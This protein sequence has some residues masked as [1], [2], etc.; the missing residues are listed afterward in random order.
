MILNYKYKL[1]VNKHTKELSQLV[2]TANCVRNHIVALYRRYYKLYGK[3]P[4]CNNM[5]KHIAKIAK[6]NPYWNLMGSQSL[7]DISQRIEIGYK[8]F[9]KKDAKRPP[10]FHKVNEHG[11]FIFKGKVGYALNGNMLIINKLKRTYKFKLTR[12]YDKVKNISISRDNLGQLWLI[13]TTEVTSHKTYER[14]D[15]GRIGMDFGLKTFITTSDNKSIDAPLPLKDNLNKLRKL[16]RNFSKKKIGSNGMRHAKK[17]LAKLHE[18]IT[19]QRTDFHWKLSHELCKSY[20]YI[21]IED[22]NLQGMIKLWGRKVSD[23][24]WGEFILKL[25]QVANKYGTE[26]VKIDR[27]ESSSQICHCCGYKN[28]NTKDLSVREWICP[29]CGTVHDRDVNAAINILEISIE[30]KGISLGS[31]DSKSIK[32]KFNLQS[33]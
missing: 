27:F 7:Q 18:K 6:S 30:G 13:V 4:S 25:Q 14:R 19:N 5:Q 24:G 17:E 28:K 10:K 3:N 33:C 8:R 9:F 23:L 22:L 26:V 15:N 31:S 29:K 2:T 32:Q 20:S 11:S 21:A 16:S 1:Y 12:L